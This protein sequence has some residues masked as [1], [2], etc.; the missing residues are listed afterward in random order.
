MLDLT[1]SDSVEPEASEPGDFDSV[2]VDA[3][4]NRFD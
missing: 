4:F 2:P 3:N 1:G